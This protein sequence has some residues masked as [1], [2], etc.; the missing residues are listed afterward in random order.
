MYILGHQADLSPLTPSVPKTG[1][2]PSIRKSASSKTVTSNSVT[3]VLFQQ[4]HILIS[5]GSS[6]GCVHILNSES[7]FGILLVFYVSA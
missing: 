3:S 4:Q 7:V 6:D 5:S 2:S 1:V